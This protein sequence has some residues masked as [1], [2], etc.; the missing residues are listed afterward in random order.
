MSADKWVVVPQI[1]PIDAFWNSEELMAL[2]AE[3]GL[4]MTRIAM[5]YDAMLA[6]RPAG[7]DVPVLVDRAE[8]E[9]L[10]RD[11]ERYRWLR[12]DA[13]TDL[14]VQ[15]YQDGFADPIDGQTLDETIDAEAAAI[16]GKAMRAASETKE[17]KK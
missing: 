12:N 17:V 15:G 2:N 16:H 1:P 11:A 8:L 13:T 5:L 7:P 3:V 10:R 9:A 6:A 14:Y 4:S